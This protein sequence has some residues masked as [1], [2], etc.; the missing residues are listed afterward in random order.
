MYG[1]AVETQGGILDEL[2]GL[3]DSGCI[4]SHM[5]DCVSWKE[6]QK[7]FQV[8]EQRKTIGKVS[9]TTHTHQQHSRAAQY[10]TAAIDCWSGLRCCVRVCSS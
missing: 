1:I 5:H 4:K 8:L 3:V 7:A 9:T 10:P 6:F 2:S